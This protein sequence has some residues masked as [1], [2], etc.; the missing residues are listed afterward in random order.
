[1]V[2]VVLLAQ[3]LVLGIG[4]KGVAALWAGS[5]FLDIAYGLAAPAASLIAGHFGY[6]AVYLLGAA[7]AASRCGAS[8]HRR[9]LRKDVDIK[10]GDQPRRIVCGPVSRCA[11][12]LRSQPLQV[13]FRR[14][15]NRRR[16]AALSRTNCH[17]EL[18]TSKSRHFLSPHRIPICAAFKWST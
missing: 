1:M 13:C 8:R 6:A 4:P 10:H 3:C 9:Q 7:C 5:A 15:T 17:L 16:L 2:G 18:S 14:N 11:Q 12:V